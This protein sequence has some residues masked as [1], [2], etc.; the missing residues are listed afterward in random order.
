MHTSQ[1]ASVHENLSVIFFANTMMHQGTLLTANISHPMV[2]DEQLVLCINYAKKVHF[3]MSGTIQLFSF[4]GF[5][6]PEC[7]YVYAC[8]TAVFVF[9][10]G[11]TWEQN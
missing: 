2:T 6:T 9:W 10:D 4:P 5:H 11:G 1:V 8:K 7:E 3:G